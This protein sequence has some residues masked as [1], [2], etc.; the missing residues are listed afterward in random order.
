[1]QNLRQVALGRRHPREPRDLLRCGNRFH[2]SRW[3]L[4]SRKQCAAQLKMVKSKR[5][6]LERR[7]VTLLVN[8]AGKKLGVS[9]SKFAQQHEDANILQ[10]TR[11]E[12]FVARLPP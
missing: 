3:Q 2:E 6:L 1:M 10:Q 4:P 7:K 5:V 8:H 11:N 9:R 12:G